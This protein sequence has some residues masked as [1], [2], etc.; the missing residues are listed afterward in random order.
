MTL[1]EQ[2]RSFIA[3]TFFVEG[4]ADDDSFLKCGIIDSTGMLELILFVE[5][6]F[7]IA[8]A[9]SELIP[10]NLGSVSALVC[11]IERKMAAAA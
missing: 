2:I 10:E 1:R 3:D 8:L 9:D 7:G 6:R 5:T 4:F 11:F